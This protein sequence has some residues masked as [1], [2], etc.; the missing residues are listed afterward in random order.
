MAPACIVVKAGWQTDERLSV[1][2]CIHQA[3]SEK[4]EASALS[5]TLRL[6]FFIIYL[7]FFPSSKFSLDIVIL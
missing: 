2:M 6:F 7:F 4:A 1:S 3:Q 5:V